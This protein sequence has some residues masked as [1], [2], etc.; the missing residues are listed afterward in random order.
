MHFEKPP[1]NSLLWNSKGAG[2]RG[3]PHETWK[4]MEKDIQRAGLTRGEIAKIA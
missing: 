1:A 4:C 3:G 2:G